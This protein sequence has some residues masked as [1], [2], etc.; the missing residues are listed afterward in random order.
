MT[1]L[2]N[3]PFIMEAILAGGVKIP[4]MPHVVLNLADRPRA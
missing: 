4:A 3:D 2:S 1:G